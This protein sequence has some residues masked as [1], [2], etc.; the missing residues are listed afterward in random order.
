[1]AVVN[2][3]HLHLFLNHVP[4]VGLVLG[5]GLF[6][7][8][9]VRRQQV[10]ERASYEVLFAIAVLTLPA[11]VTGLGAQAVLLDRADVS[12]AAIDAHQDAA[13]LAFAGMQVT[14][15]AAWLALWRLRRNLEAGPGVAGTVLLLAIV[16]LVLM[17]GAAA[18]GGEIRHPETRAD[19]AVI[20]SRGPM[21]VSSIGAFVTGQAW[22][23]PAAETLHFIG[24]SLLFG[25]MAVINLRVLG[26]M[27]MVSFQ[28]LHRLLPWAV[29]GFAINLSTGTLFLASAPEQY[30]E[31][32]PFFWKTGL[33]AAGGGSLLYLTVADRPWAVDAGES[34]PAIDRAIATGALGLWVAVM[35]LG[36]ML[37]F[38]GT[39]F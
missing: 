37:P 15:G 19:D 27:K 4:T 33:L 14:G 8:A 10:L 23:W 28:A 16:T 32:V 21:P 34:A 7:L 18:V 17:T 22:V 9:L 11:Y 26:M 13:L 20:A 3:A 38:L 2:A 6:L 25:V 30:A 29:V 31:S 1:M 24:L 36:R 12:A 35:Y 39:S 5:V